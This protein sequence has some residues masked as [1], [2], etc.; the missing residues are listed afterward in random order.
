MTIQSKKESMT[1]DH[2]RLSFWQRISPFLDV[3]GAVL[4]FGSW[5]LSNAMSQKAQD[6]AKTHQ[7][8]IGRVTQFR[9]YDDFAYRI[10]EIQSDLVRT[11]KLVENMTEDTKLL[12]DKTL[13]ISGVPTWT[14][15]TATQVRELN[16]VVRDFE[17]YATQLSTSENITQLIEKA[18]NSTSLLSRAFG[19]ARDEYDL[20]VEKRN[21]STLPTH[22]DKTAEKEL[23]KRVDNLW[24]NYDKAKQ[25]M[26]QVS[27]K[28]IRTADTESKSARHLS[29]QCKRLS[30]VLYII[31]TLIILFGRAKSVFGSKK[32]NV[33]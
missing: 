6:H 19:S 5:I 29:K 7:S 12:D 32:K 26:L 17:H 27:D 8:I 31:G 25:K 10:S 18:L 20:L 9:L 33:E 16:D 24:N 1:T 23:L 11:R 22:S 28:L 30:Y 3:I 21:Q 14:G 2:A 15:M 13:M 4:I